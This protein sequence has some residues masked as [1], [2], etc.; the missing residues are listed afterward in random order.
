MERISKYDYFMKIA[1][2]VSERSTCLRRHYGAVIVKDDR[3]VSTGY[4]GAA[5][6]DYNCCDTGECVRDTM[7]I[8]HGERYELC[9][10]VHAEANAILS[11][12]EDLT[13]TTIYIHGR[14][15]KTNHTVKGTPCKMCE[16]LIKNAKIKTVYISEPDLI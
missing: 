14:D 1:D 10:A 16:R 8:P 4:N 3:I 9:R 15:A 11:A 2:C 7:N 13:G 5:V 6:G 12:R